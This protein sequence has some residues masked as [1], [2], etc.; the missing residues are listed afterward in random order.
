MAEF[1]AC[2][3]GFGN[4]GRKKDLIKQSRGLFIVPLVANDGTRN[5]IAVGDTVD[6]AYVTA[7]INQADSSKRWYP[8][9]DL[10]NVEDVRA[11][12]VFETFNDGTRAKTRQGN[13]TFTGS[14]IQ[15][16]SIFK[17]KLDTFGCSLIG[18]YYVDDCHDLVGAIS[19]DEQTL[20]PVPIADGS[21]DIVLQKATD[22][23]TGRVQIGFDISALQNDSSLRVLKGLDFSQFSGLLDVNAAISNI[24]T[25]G[26]TATMT[27]D[28]G[29]FQEP[30]KVRGLVAGDFDLYN[31]TASAVVT[32]STVTET[33]PGVYA[34]T[35]A[36]QTSGDD[37]TLSLDKDG[38]EMAEKDIEIP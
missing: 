3:S 2:T 8:I 10:K 7:K 4:T 1:C 9:Q 31:E 32:I 12:S 18:I 5:G 34:F 14:A 21:L 25:T 17:G 27:L 11:E 20:Y 33:A 26:F 30:E 22:S 38:F 37:L 6:E 24:S 36:S 23:A 19:D 29:S 16:G 15:Q 13:R 35:F 28:Y